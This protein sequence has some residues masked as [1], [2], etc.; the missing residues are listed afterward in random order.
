MKKLLALLLL[1]AFIPATGQSLDSAQTKISVMPDTAGDLANSTSVNASG[2]FNGRVF[3]GYLA[4]PESAFYPGQIWQ[5]GS[6]QYEDAWYHD[7]PIMYD[8]FKDEVLVRHPTLIP[9]KLVSERVA[10]F[11]LGDK[12]FIRVDGKQ[13]GMPAT[14]FYELLVDGKMRILVQHQKKMEETF[15]NM[16]VE[17]NFVLH[18][19]Y[20][21]IKDGKSYLVKK[22]GTLL[23]LMGNE[24][25]EISRVLRQQ[26]LKFKSNR[27]ETIVQIA[28]LYNQAHR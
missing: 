23:D 2:V 13:A 25:Q 9:V 16:S 18:N 1:P 10:Q 27:E 17:R 26:D 22:Q 20:Y 21:A 11:S 5:T 3:Y 4:T 15:A 19:S 8:A 14:G 28:R 7:V 12:K 6:V 24:R